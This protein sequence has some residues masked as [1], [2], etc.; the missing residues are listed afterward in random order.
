ML[1][2]CKESRRLAEGKMVKMFGTFVNVETEVLWFISLNSSVFMDT[3]GDL[4][5]DVYLTGADPADNCATS[6]WRASNRIKRLMVTSEMWIRAIDDKR[7]HHMMLGSDGQ[8][9]TTFIN[10]R[11]LSLVFVDYPRDM[12]GRLYQD[13]RKLRQADMLEEPL[14]WEIRVD[15]DFISSVRGSLGLKEDDG[16]IEVNVRTIQKGDDGSGGGRAEAIGDSSGGFWENLTTMMAIEGD[17][18]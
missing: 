9:K 6:K 13:D 16:R 1:L 17:T 3:F 12:A 11:E 5:M 18:L 14:G 4:M 2:A 10:L 7:N 8:F 15:E